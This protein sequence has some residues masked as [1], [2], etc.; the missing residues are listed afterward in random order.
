VAKPT[1]PCS[2]SLLFP[3]A[4]KKERRK[5]IATRRG[6]G[7][8]PQN[9]FNSGQPSGSPV[10]RGGGKKKRKNHSARSIPSPEKTSRRE[11]KEA[12]LMVNAYGEEKEKGER[13]RGVV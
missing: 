7:K 10:R 11:G 8:I 6:G 1:P 9:D 4:H 2:G 13:G 12:R 5:R 3:T